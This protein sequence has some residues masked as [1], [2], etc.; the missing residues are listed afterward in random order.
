MGDVR[1]AD[2]V[3]LSPGQLLADA[4]WEK[5]EHHEGE[6]GNGRTTTWRRATSPRTGTPE[7]V[8]STADPHMHTNLRQL[9]LDMA[10]RPSIRPEECDMYLFY[11]LLMRRATVDTGA[12]IWVAT[13]CAE[14]HIAFHSSQ[15]TQGGTRFNAT[16]PFVV[17][18]L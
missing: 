18:P 3:A 1:I 10:H 8:Y 9:R 2:Q 12:L 14:G 16:C 17:K 6:P 11:L 7:Y 15:E 5:V 13:P 4:E